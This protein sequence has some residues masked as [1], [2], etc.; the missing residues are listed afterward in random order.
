LNAVPTRRHS[1]LIIALLSSALLIGIALPFL[2]APPPAQASQSK[3]GNGI[4]MVN[5]FYAYANGDESLFV[6]ADRGSI[7]VTDPNGYFSTGSGARAAAGTA[8]VWR[9][10]V[11]NGTIK[12]PGA[13]RID[14]LKDGTAIPGR[15][16]SESYVTNQGTVQNLT[17]WAV[18]LNGLIYRIDLLNMN[19]AYSRIT[20]DAIG[21]PTGSDCRPSY[22]S[23]EFQGNN[24]DD[25]FPPL[26]DCGSRFKI[27]FEE[28]N[29]DL[30]VEAQTW[31]GQ[32]DWI[33]P[34][35]ITRETIVVENFAFAQSPTTSAGLFTWT[36]D[37]FM[38]NYEVQID[39]DDNGSY[40]DPV[41]RVI[42]V[43]GGPGAYSANFDGR[44]GQGQTIPFGTPMMARLWFDKIGEFH[45]VMDD[46]EGRG[47]LTLTRL[48]GD[49]EGDTTLYW[50]DTALSSSGRTSTTAQVDGRAGVD[51]SAGVHGWSAASGTNSWG[52]NRSIED[53]AYAQPLAT[54]RAE[55][56]IGVV[57][58]VSTKSSLP[59]STSP[60]IPGQ[61]VTYT[62]T[63]AGA[64][65]RQA[66]VKTTESLAKV[67]D[68][69]SLISGPTSSLDSL[70]VGQLDANGSF[71]ITG[72]V[73]AGQTA[74]VT[75][76]VE[77]NQ[78]STGDDQLVSVL[79]C[80]PT[81]LNCQEIQATHPV[82]R[83]DFEHE[84]TTTAGPVLRVGDQVTREYRVSNVGQA[85]LAAFHFQTEI[86]SGTGPL[87]PLTCPST[88]LPHDQSV[89][90]TQTYALTQADIDAG[91]LRSRV[92]AVGRTQA[93][94]QSEPSQ[95]FPSQTQ[96]ADLII[97]GNPSLR[98][99]T[100]ASPLP[101]GPTQLDQPVTYQFTITN[102][103]NTSLF[104]VGVQVTTFSGSPALTVNC[105]DS[106]VTPLLPN[107]SLT[108]SATYRITQADIDRGYLNLTARATSKD[109]HHNPGP[110][111]YSVVTDLT[112]VQAPQLGLVK[113]G[114]LGSDGFSVN[115]ALTYVFDVTNL[116]NVTISSLEIQELSFSGAGGLLPATCPVTLLA[117]GASVR[118]L[119]T[120]TI[121]QPDVDAS[122][123]DNSAI[124]TGQDPQGD[125]V[126]SPVASARV[127]GDRAPALSLRSSSSTPAPDQPWP[128]QIVDL[129]FE[130]TNTGNVSVTNVTIAPS[131]FTGSPT[132]QTTCPPHSA[133][134]PG[135]QIVCQA[136]Y[137][138]TQADI[139]LG[140]VAHTATAHADA[141]GGA[142]V[143]SNQSQTEVQL[144]HRPGATLT[145]TADSSGLSTA[146]RAGQTVVYRYSL[147]NTG[148]VTLQQ[149][150]IVDHLPGVSAPTY[151]WPGTAGRLAPG[152]T[153][154]AQASYQLQQ[155]DV[156]AGSI[157][158]LVNSSGQTPAGVPAP[159]AGPAS[160]NTTLTAAPALSLDKA[161]DISQ[162]P[163]T[164]STG[165]LINYQFT[166]TNTGNV[167][168]SDV[169]L[170]DPLPG[171]SALTYNWPGSAGRLAPGQTVTAQATYRL[172][173]A[174]LDAGKVTNSA[175]AGAKAPNQSPLTDPPQDTVTVSLSPAPLLHLTKAAD[176][177]A[178]TV[179]PEA[180]QI[181]TYDFSVT[182]AGNVTAHDVEVIDQ[183]TG[184]GVLTY[185]WPGVAGVLTPGQVATARTTYRL[186][187]ADIDAGQLSN[188]ATVTGKAPNGS[189][190][191]P[192]AGASAQV[193]LAP[194]GAI[195]LI[196]AADRSQLSDP[197]AAG[198][199]VAYSF[200]A[201]NVG[202]V[203]LN[204]VVITDPLP[205][206]DPLVEVWPGTPGQLAPGQTVTAQATYRLTQTDLDAGRLSNTATARGVT[207]AG[208]SVT[209]SQF[210]VSFP[211]ARA[212]GLSLT[213]LADTSQLSDPPQSGQTVTYDFSVTNAGNVTVS[214][215]TVIDPLPGL[216]ALTYAWPGPVGLLAP[217]QTVT[218]QATYHLTQADLDAG[219][220]AS[221]ATAEGVGPDRLALPNPP[222][223]PLTTPLT[224]APGLSLG[225]GVYRLLDA[226]AD[227]RIGSGD[228]WQTLA[229]TPQ[230]MVY[231]FEVRNTGNVTVHDVSLTHRQFTGAR[232][233]PTVTCPA[234]AAALAPGQAVTCSARYL[235]S[236]ADVDAGDVLSQVGA[237]GQPAGGPQAPAQVASPLASALI[238]S[239][240][241]PA[242]TVEA[243]PSMTDPADFTVGA[244][245]EFTFN[246]TNT[247][248][249]TLS[250]PSVAV[251]SFNGHTSLDQIDC[252][253]DPLAPGA[254]VV[255]QVTHVLNQGDIDARRVDL[256]VTASGASPGSR[257]SGGL[258]V[259][260]VP[261]PADAA[262][263]LGLHQPALSLVK[264]SSA[265]GQA[266]LT[267]GE[268]VTYSFVVRNTGNVTMS[269][270]DLVD[271]DF[272]GFGPLSDVACPTDQ[273]APDQSMT[274]QA[275]Y[276]V[277]LE[278]IDAGGLTNHATVTGLGPV[279]LD[280]D[281]PATVE[282]D[283]QSALPAQAEPRLELIQTGSRRTDGPTS[284]GE[285]VDYRFVVLNTG[286]VTVQELTV[287]GQA[288]SGAGPLSDVVCQETTLRPGESTLCWATYALTATEVAQG[289]LLTNLAV[290]S[291]V[292]A[293]GGPV[294]S[295]EAEAEV[296]LPLPETGAPGGLAVWLVAAGLSLLG[297]WALLLLRRRTRRA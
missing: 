62:L 102:N 49:G 219:R 259:T 245:V 193:T 45:L 6:S 272:S 240:H 134:A 213:K 243:T 226:P 56:P 55:M 214:Q 198:Q 133:L 254:L 235:L 230:E 81:Q 184:L 53:W 31:A 20:A 141:A 42:A 138:L 241:Q 57:P 122:V 135:D 1:R 16:W 73:P 48:N 175:R 129:S 283:S 264:S 196:K 24:T 147:T 282:D 140:R 252:P 43:S 161:A 33:L 120:Y 7:V 144:S 128:G 227:G 88:V 221:T 28:P 256:T 186:T 2:S 281:H 39:V 280:D 185:A 266:I 145:T 80:D 279:P 4:M 270:I 136:S 151:T 159:D 8:G 277:T 38:G 35:P 26:L 67:L 237:S 71:S 52:D 250:D 41:D 106:S 22:T 32:S 77:V 229:E 265:A 170:T 207:P 157:H 75:Y 86:F 236:Q 173:Q 293:Q 260:P 27:F 231:L 192:Q 183:L 190:L 208:A 233:I 285:I 288:F 163:T 89:L 10:R 115:S 178:L 15:V 46:I 289:G 44:D 34:P 11:D 66:T 188:T 205:G 297:G 223:A 194:D 152:Q 87:G 142:G 290:A 116:G 36:M 29:I 125:L 74:T 60:V 168:L 5:V 109:I 113:S 114:Q 225:R 25:W 79:A 200:S 271:D 92:Y 105:P 61:T 238:E 174:D 247:G 268:E 101:S 107:A 111:S 217:G 165:D 3:V 13:W 210:T 126:S 234:E 291:G 47:G 189:T 255:C 63:F 72:T 273:L 262:F 99:A 90:C 70:Q 58:V 296:Q 286:N 30:P 292:T 206:L 172:V 117:P 244:E 153:V 158:N 104:D 19:G 204:Q 131:A 139:D 83:I 17:Y 181:V 148:N 216:S 218:A 96:T 64:G 242:L 84:I 156:D 284:L 199:T 171:L 239:Q 275:T 98:I 110:Y 228:S 167:T 103:G 253:G 76:A 21:I 143:T 95:E 176:T 124:A 150:A 263:V 191:P 251:V 215:V 257:A 93:G 154:T 267:V 278:D 65:G 177:S 91:S 202:N 51:S 23:S 274:C 68:D 130:V 121:S 195:D 112:L 248:N 118:C 155:T 246:V 97:A 249:V 9:I 276:V 160:A 40:A 180:G 94:A 162:L 146:P 18:N 164:P 123:F 269:S 295:V 166:A 287:V 54:P 78:S 85:D 261:S 119:T 108:C 69:A 137:V 224:A 82:G 294:E 59:S 220:V 169:S 100:A 127:S 182:N 37:K 12:E 197:P 212:Q 222:Q 149:T 232:P 132:P 258:P 203:T 209:P 211:L 201:T 187:Q 14:V 50:N 179:P